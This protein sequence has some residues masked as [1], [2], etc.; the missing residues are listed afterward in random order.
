[1][2]VRD[3]SGLPPHVVPAGFAVQE[4]Y[5]ERARHPIPAGQTVV[6]DIGAPR[7]MEQA[8]RILR[9]ATDYPAAHVEG[10]RTALQTERD[11]MAAG[12]DTAETQLRADT[13]A[14]PERHREHGIARLQ[15]ESQIRA[16]DAM[17]EALAEALK[18]AKSNDSDRKRRASD[19]RAEAKVIAA[20]V[21]SMD[22]HVRALWRF[23]HAERRALIEGV[24]SGHPAPQTA[25]DIALGRAPADVD[26]TRLSGPIN[27]PYRLASGQTP[28]AEP[29]P[30]VRPVFGAKLRVTNVG[31]IAVTLPGHG[32]DLKTLYPGDP[33]EPGTACFVKTT[34]ANAVTMLSMPGLRVDLVVATK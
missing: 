17:I 34:T 2:M 19:A 1:M 20:E 25:T 10:V 23:A 24:N 6:L 21:P 4:R 11:E 8:D 18:L 16:H 15:I 13:L 14:S 26:L 31:G 27:L 32:L 9:S 7:R 3:L 28:P 29:L 22:D 33:S 5:D 30:A 12:L